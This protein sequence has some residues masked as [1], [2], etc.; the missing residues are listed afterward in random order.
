MHHGNHGERCSTDSD[1]AA[2][3]APASL[4]LSCRIDISK[5]YSPVACWIK[6]QPRSIECASSSVITPQVIKIKSF[7][8]WS[9]LLK[10]DSISQ[11]CSVAFNIRWQRYATVF[12]FLIDRYRRQRKIVFGKTAPSYA[13]LILERAMRPRRQPPNGS[14]AI[15]AKIESEGQSRIARGSGKRFGV[16]F[17]LHGFPIKPRGDM[18]KTPGSSLAEFT[19][20]NHDWFGFIC[21][22]D[23]YLSAMASGNVLHT[24][25]LLPRR[26]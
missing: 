19:M 21:T 1:T 7:T 17:N 25:L 18:E 11:P 6:H 16:P 15:G 10:G 2:C 9:E 14:A 22:D 23:L 20:A 3:N 13:Y 24:C 4:L 12:V 26:S 8:I 5:V